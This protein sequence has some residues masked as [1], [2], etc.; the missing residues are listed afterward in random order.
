M[1]IV[2]EQTQPPHLENRR[3]N[4]QFQVYINERIQRLAYKV[5]DIL[6]WTPPEN[7]RIMNLWKGWLVIICL[8]WIEPQA[9]LV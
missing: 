3:N 6:F 2:A 8:S 4:S 9:D 7:I 1:Q 5:L